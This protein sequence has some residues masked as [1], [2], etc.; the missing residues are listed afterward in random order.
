MN[1]DYYAVSVE[2]MD[3]DFYKDLDGYHRP[4]SYTALYIYDH[5]PSDVDI[6][7]SIERSG[8]Y[9][10]EWLPQWTRA[11]KEKWSWGTDWL[12]D[13]FLSDPDTTMIGFATI[14]RLV[15]VHIYK[16]KMNE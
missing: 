4:P 13:K 9:T 2:I 5:F 1:K 8:P 7:A 11:V 12:T 16:R 3:Y 10:R 14:P 6:K 15:V